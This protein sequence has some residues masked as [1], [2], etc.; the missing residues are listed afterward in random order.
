MS[1][2]Q[3]SNNNPQSQKQ[4]TS[5][6][7]VSFSN[8][9]NSPYAIWRFNLVPSHSG[10]QSSNLSSIQ[11]QQYSSSLLQNSQQLSSPSRQSNPSA[12]NTHQQHNYQ[13]LNS[14]SQNTQQS[15]TNQ[16]SAGAPVGGG[17]GGGASLSKIVIAQVFLLLSTLKE[18]DKYDIQV[19]QIKEV[20][21]SNISVKSPRF[22][23][24][25]CISPVESKR[26]PLTIF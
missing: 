16:A 8:Y 23:L 4:A 18:G 20:S 7:N 10:S 25:P 3:S 21:A 19:K 5:I 2:Q 24:S 6:S 11:K 12:G 14:Y 15:N 17:G 1:N 13:L 26:N 9:S 22:L